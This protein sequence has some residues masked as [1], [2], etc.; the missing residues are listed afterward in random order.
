MNKVPAH[1]R[2][3]SRGVDIFDKLLFYT[4]PYSVVSKEK[5]F[6]YLKEEDIMIVKIEILHFY[7]SVCHEKYPVTKIWQEHNLLKIPTDI[8]HIILWVISVIHILYCL[9][10]RQS[11]GGGLKYLIQFDS[12]KK[13]ITL[14]QFPLG[15]MGGPCREQGPPSAPPRLTLRSVPH[16]H[17][18]ICFWFTC[19][20]GGVKKNEKNAVN[21]WH[22]VPY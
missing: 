22:L 21:C 13:I 8:T 14:R 6:D 5:Y 10:S 7:C 4:N 9:F 3:K 18:R 20:G 19:L 15:T 1:K 17:Q 11:M 2:T 12:D 16:L